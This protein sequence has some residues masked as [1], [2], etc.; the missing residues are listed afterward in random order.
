MNKKIHGGEKNE[1]EYKG[2]RRQVRR[3]KAG[4]GT[5]SGRHTKE[6]SK[7][8]KD[9]KRKRGRGREMTKEGSFG[10]KLCCSAASSPG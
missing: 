9:D 8:V 6:S 7:R 5:T 10:E 3:E 4:G 2:G 1:I